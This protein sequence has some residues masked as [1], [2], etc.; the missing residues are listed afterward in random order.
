M[1]LLPREAGTPR[2]RK[3]AAINDLSEHLVTVRDP[4]G[5]AAEAYR[6]LRT[7]LIY[8]SA[9]APPKVV[10]LTSPGPRE[11]KSTSCAN[12]GVTL[13]RAGKNT[14]IIDC[15]LHDPTMHEIFGTSPR[16]GLVNAL[17]EK[18]DLHEVSQTMLPHLE[19]LAAGPMTPDPAELLTSQQFAEL[20]ARV[21]RGYDYVLLDAPAVNVFS[22]PAILAPQ[23]DGV[24][25]VLDSRETRREALRESTRRLEAVGANLMGCV[26]NNAERFRS[27]G[28][29]YV[30]GRP[31]A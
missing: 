16:P 3:E 29:P 31:R 12:L 10:L 5:A 9:D 19:L 7:N 1:P 13:A 18:R 24:L 21:R 14:L 28:P 23:A 17:V 20:I 6:S 30:A 22:D 27:A 15:D 8:A 11:G 4:A 26:M 25:L 2:M